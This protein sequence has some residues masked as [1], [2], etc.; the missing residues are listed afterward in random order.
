[1]VKENKK[2]ERPFIL[3]LND[4]KREIFEAISEISQRHNIPF[5]I[6]EYILSEAMQQVKAGADKEVLQAKITYDRYLSDNS[7]K[8]EE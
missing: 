1:M 8:K 7:E 4:G 3:E 5:Y 6:L 2:V